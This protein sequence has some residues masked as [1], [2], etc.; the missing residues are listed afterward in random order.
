MSACEARKPGNAQCD[1]K[2]SVEFCWPGAGRRKQCQAHAVLAVRVAEALGF[3]LELAPIAEPA[4]P[5]EPVEIPD[6]VL[7]FDCR[8][9]NASLIREALR[10]SLREAREEVRAEMGTL[11]R[12]RLAEIK[13]A[14]VTLA[15]HIAT[16]EG[17]VNP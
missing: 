9:E 11:L 10:K 1:Q 7:G 14:T 8:R 5:S 13:K 16:L 6:T 12:A 4:G 3:V 17:E 15:L 2:A